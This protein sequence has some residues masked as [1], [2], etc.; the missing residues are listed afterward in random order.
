MVGVLGHQHLGQQP[1]GG[2]ALVDHV[3]CHRRL[4]DRLAL[5]TG[6]LAAHVPL[7]GEHAGHVVQ[8]LGDVLA[9]AP[10]L[11]AAGAQGVLGFVAD[12]PARPGRRQRCPLGLA[13]GLTGR[14]CRLQRRDLPRDG[15]QVRVQRLVQQVP[16]L[17]VE[18]LG[19]GGELQAFEDRVLVREL[20]DDG[21]LERHLAVVALHLGLQARQHRAHLR[22]GVQLVQVLRRDHGQR[23]CRHCAILRIGALPDCGVLRSRE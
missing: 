4:H 22:R 3:R 10:H 20:V 16:L 19:L 13:L 14:R 5:R 15:L 6:P 17:G 1:G 12:L 23:S 7:H 8:L 21:L 18:P 2:D 11:A 9:D